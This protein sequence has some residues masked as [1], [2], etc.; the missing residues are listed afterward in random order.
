MTALDPDDPLYLEFE[1]EASSSDSDSSDN[2][3][4]EVGEVLDMLDDEGEDAEDEAQLQLLAYQDEPAPRDPG[5]AGGDGN[6][7]DGDAQAAA[8]DITRLDST[9]W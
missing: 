2:D 6:A 3:D 9:N 5:R 4:G 8:A 7:N 1:E